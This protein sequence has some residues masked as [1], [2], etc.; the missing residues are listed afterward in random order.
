[1]L[2]IYLFFRKNNYNNKK[3]GYSL[4]IIQCFFQEVSEHFLL[5][6][7]SLNFA[8]LFHR[9]HWLHWLY[10]LYWLFFEWNAVL[11]TLLWDINCQFLKLRRGTPLPSLTL[12]FL[13][14]SIFILGCIAYALLHMFGVQFF[15]SFFLNC[16]PTLRLCMWLGA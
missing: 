16:F 4:S 9:F 3:F 11:I 8:S 15:N 6:F 2:I 14:N 13:Q 7:S 5:L 10:W 1:M 12:V